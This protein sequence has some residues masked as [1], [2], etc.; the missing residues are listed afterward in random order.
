MRR[1]H[2]F[3]SALPV[4]LALVTVAPGCGATRVAMPSEKE[5]ADVHAGRKSVV[6]LRGLVKTPKGNLRTA[7]G[8]DAPGDSTRLCRADL[9]GYGGL[10]SPRRRGLWSAGRLRSP[11]RA[12]LRDGWVYLVLRPGTYYLSA[13]RFSWEPAPAYAS[14]FD[15]PAAGAEAHGW[16]LDVPPGA[17]T[18]YAGTLTFVGVTAHGHVG[19]SGPLARVGDESS[20]AQA[21][22]AAFLPAL[23]P[24][25]P[26]VM[27]PYLGAIDRAVASRLSATDVHVDGAPAAKGFDVHAAVV[28]DGS[29]AG[30]EVLDMMG[31]PENDAGMAGLV[32]LLGGAA[33]AGGGAVSGAIG[34]AAAAREFQP[35]VDELVKQAGQFDT[36]GRLRDAL[37]KPLAG[38]GVATTVGEGG[39]TLYLAVKAVRL[40]P[41]ERSH[42]A[43]VEV[44]VRARVRDPRAGRH[45]MDRVVL[46]S[47]ARARHRNPPDG[48]PLEPYVWV[49]DESP[50]LDLRAL[51]K[52][53][54]DERRRRVEAELE[55]AVTVI[56]HRILQDVRPGAAGSGRVSEKKR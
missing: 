22:A 6:L 34:G 17:P 16:L 42:L 46:Y 12:A 31:K 54:P 18:V 45:Y 7:F 35:C 37:R 24:A 38:R 8:P 11:T 36:A 30:I 5:L 21:L 49:L 56:S 20:R 51:A 29:R 48:V 28:Q 43:C 53:P 15:A 13:D 9:D 25:R 3:M 41:C 32:I 40:P 4:L 2:S 14:R 52:L 27:Q 44:R 39:P 10:G 47:N 19:G 26:A 1:H 55:R 50:A 23:P 33:W